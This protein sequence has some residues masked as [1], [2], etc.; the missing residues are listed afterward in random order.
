VRPSGEKTK[1]AVSETGDL[2]I[3]LL[4]FA[5]VNGGCLTSWAIGTEQDESFRIADSHEATFELLK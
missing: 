5:F 4:A 1:F 2:G 3:C